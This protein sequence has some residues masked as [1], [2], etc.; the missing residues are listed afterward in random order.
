MQVVEME[1]NSRITS[2]YDTFSMLP[3]TPGIPSECF[4]GDFTGYY[5]DNWIALSRAMLSPNE[6]EVRLIV[7]E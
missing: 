6:I 5:N 3:Q 4:G 2:T 7:N 1:P